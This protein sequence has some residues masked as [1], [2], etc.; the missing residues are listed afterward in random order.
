MARGLWG[1]RISA[2]LSSRPGRVMTG[3]SRLGGVCMRMVAGH[4]VLGSFRRAESGLGRTLLVLSAL[5]SG[6]R[7][8]LR[9]RAG[10]TFPAWRCGRLGDN[11][12]A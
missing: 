12:P 2:L 4:L 7:L 5:C 1:V 9:V 6:A 3:L 10:V 11:V 8:A